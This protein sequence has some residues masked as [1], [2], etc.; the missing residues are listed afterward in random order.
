MKRAVLLTVSVAILVAC[1]A[2]AY[3]M[4][5]GDVEL[6]L[7]RSLSY[8]M[9]LGILL[10]ATLVI[11]AVAGV[12]A[13]A[14]QQIARRLA[15]WGERRKAKTEAQIESLN[16]SG[17]ALAWDGEIE[18]SRGV[19]KKA[20]RR[21]PH[22]KTAALALAASY[23]DTG[24][25]DA[26]QDALRAAVEQEPGDPDLRYALAEALRRNGETAGAIRMHESIRIQ[27]PHAPRVLVALR[28][29]YAQTEQWGDAV[30]IQER[31]L[32]ELANSQ[33]L[34]RE[35]ER[36]R[37][38][39]CRAAQNLPDANARLSAL[40][41]ILDEDRDF[42][43]A[44][45]AAGDTLV[46]LGRGAEASTLWEKAFRR[47]PAVRLARKLLAVQ[48]DNAGRRRVV[49]LIDKFAARLPADDVHLLRASAALESDALETAQRE[50][51]LVDDATSIA[52][53]Q[54]WADLHQ[55]RGDP[56]RALQ[57]L[58]PIAG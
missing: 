5:P 25:Y 26:A 11:G 34:Q 49:A 32:G 58:R 38:Y 4:N 44:V 20:W 31:Y 42:A 10:V 23:A 14:L 33:G 48:T 52:A 29:L 13:I 47:A 57:T 43:S 22:N 41:A 55:K 1:I 18:R 28:D 2:Y 46:E 30:A 21:D 3:T 56:E 45:E 16:A 27:Y 40:Q 15:T 7:S 51:E 8:R 6:R 35:R 37:E 24:E 53:Q 54:C 50:L 39:R 19:L 36:L 17:A 9:P 12:L